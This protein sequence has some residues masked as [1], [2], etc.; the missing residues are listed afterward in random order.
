V[1]ASV[2]QERRAAGSD[3]AVGRCI[4]AVG[5]RLGWFTVELPSRSRPER[6]HP[7]LAGSTS[8]IS[9]RSLASVV[10]T[11]LVTEDPH[12]RDT[13]EERRENAVEDPLSGRRDLTWPP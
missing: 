1:L 5:L 11:N 13:C 10:V 12:P 4:S 8:A 6:I 3:S 7:A 2:S 9:R